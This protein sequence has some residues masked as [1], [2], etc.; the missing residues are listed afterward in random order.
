M[1][2]Q[3][4]IQR[5]V[6]SGKTAEQSEQYGLLHKNMALPFVPFVGLEIWVELPEYSSATQA[7]RAIKLTSVGWSSKDDRFFCMDR[8]WFG[9]ELKS[10]KLEDVDIREYLEEEVAVFWDKFGLGA[11]N[12]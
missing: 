8:D 1:E 5:R 12:S 7:H 9:D 10:Y 6:W 3:V 2:Y 11:R 4:T